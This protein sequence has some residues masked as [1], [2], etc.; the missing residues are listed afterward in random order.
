LTFVRGPHGFLDRHFELS[1]Y[2]LPSGPS[3]VD[4]QILA[5]DV[6]ARIAGQQQQRAL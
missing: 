3:A 2:L 5:S 6:A 4:D 1:D